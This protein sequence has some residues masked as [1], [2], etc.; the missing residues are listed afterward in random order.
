MG[1]QASI[2]FE[3]LEPPLGTSTLSWGCAGCL[4]GHPY[5]PLTRHSPGGTPPTPKE[6]S[7]LLPA[8]PCLGL[9]PVCYQASGWGVE[10]ASCAPGLHP[11]APTAGH[12]LVGPGSW[13]ATAG[14]DRGGLA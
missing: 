9:V 6:Q 11:P 5:H 14:S 8:R 3:L 7:L 2:W 10:P 13:G 12:L 1:R 4:D